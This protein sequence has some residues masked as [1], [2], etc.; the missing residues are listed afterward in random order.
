MSNHPA[1]ARAGVADRPRAGLRS[2]QGVDACMWR[3]GDGGGNDT[4]SPLGPSEERKARAPETLAPQSLSGTG[5]WSTPKVTSAPAAMAPAENPPSPE[6]RS[7][8]FIAKYSTL[9]A[10]HPYMRTLREHTQGAH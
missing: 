10:R 3:W 5:S 2:V 8:T 6:K 9:I 1:R 7:T 4:S